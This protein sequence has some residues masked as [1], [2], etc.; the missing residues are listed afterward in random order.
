[1][2]REAPAWYIDS[3]SGAAANTVACAV[4]VPTEVLKQQMQVQG[5]HRSISLAEAIAKV[6]LIGGL[7]GFY[8]GFGATSSRELAFAF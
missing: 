4:R 8:R 7:R 5:A 6:H 1:A 2:L 3:T